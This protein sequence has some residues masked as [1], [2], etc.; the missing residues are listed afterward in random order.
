MRVGKESSKSRCFSNKSCVVKICNGL[1]NKRCSLNSSSQSC[2]TISGLFNYPTIFLNDASEC[3]LTFNTESLFVSCINVLGNGK[4][5]TRWCTNL[6]FSWICSCTTSGWLYYA[7]S[8]S[9]AISSI[10]I[11]E[12]WNTGCVL[13]QGHILWRCCIRFGSIIGTSSSWILIV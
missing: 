7:S 3:V 11:C 8:E 2:G 13:R 9:S 5:K 10:D 1:V 12:Q 6:C 4:G